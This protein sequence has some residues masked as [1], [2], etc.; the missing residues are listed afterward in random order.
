MYFFPLY[1]N[2]YQQIEFYISNVHS[3][4]ASGNLILAILM[5]QSNF[6]YKKLEDKM[7][8]FS[9]Q[10]ICVVQNTERIHYITWSVWKNNLNKQDLNMRILCF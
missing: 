5:M 3:I 7:I 4:P 10:D 6:D 2:L 8:F 1:Q 9:L